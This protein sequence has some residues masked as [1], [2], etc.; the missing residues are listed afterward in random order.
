MLNNKEREGIIL[1][2]EVE[3][4]GKERVWWVMDKICRWMLKNDT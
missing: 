1:E 4:I 2:N 3:S